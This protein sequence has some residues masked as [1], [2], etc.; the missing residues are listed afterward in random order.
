MSPIAPATDT[1]VEDLCR[2]RLEAY[3][4]KGAEEISARL[5]HPFQ[6]KAVQLLIDDKGA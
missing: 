6:R 5:G 4:W 1:Q 2:R 3:T